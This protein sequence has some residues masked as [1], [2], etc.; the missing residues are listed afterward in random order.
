MPGS[1]FSDVH[2]PS[3]ELLTQFETRI[4]SE[5]HDRTSSTDHSW[6]DLESLARLVPKGII[7]PI[8]HLT[9]TDVDAPNSGTIEELHPYFAPPAPK[10]ADPEAPRLE[11]AEK[12]VLDDLREQSE[13]FLS[14]DSSHLSHLEQAV[15][16]N[17]SSWSLLL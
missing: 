15:G 16:S 10:G 14:Q 9:L 6:T 2:S 3:T 4:L 7:P 17:L 5:L 8:I 11:A 1:I 13:W 12:L